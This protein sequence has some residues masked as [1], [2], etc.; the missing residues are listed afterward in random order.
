MTLIT[1]IV[2]VN[3]K[4]NKAIWCR[5]LEIVLK[6][7]L[8]LIVA[9]FILKIA[10]RNNEKSEKKDKAIL[11]GHFRKFSACNNLLSYSIVNLVLWLF[12]FFLVCFSFAKGGLAFDDYTV[13]LTANGT[14]KEISCNEITPS[15][16]I[17]QEYQS[18]CTKWINEC[19]Q[20]REWWPELLEGVSWLGGS[21]AAMICLI[22]TRKFPD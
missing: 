8:I 20:M 1:L 11:R 19:R 7:L 22:L 15:S 6:F 14:Y 13:W 16:P 4:G 21:G 5:A 2:I 9:V 18:E 10:T 12:A 17:C 3:I